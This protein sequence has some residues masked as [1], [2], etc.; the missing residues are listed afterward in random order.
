MVQRPEGK[1]RQRSGF[2]LIEILIVVVILGILAAIVVPQFAEAQASARATAMRT[3]LNTIRSQVSA[4]RIQN[5]NAMP[6]GDGATAALMMQTLIDDGYIV[7]TIFL[8]GGFSWVWDPTAGEL[9]LAYDE[10][11]EPNIPDADNDGD[12]DQ[13]DVTIIESW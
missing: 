9:S 8:S 3:Q 7:R 11:A 2:T 13:E 6:G 4:W 12:G 10:A 1:F 5:G